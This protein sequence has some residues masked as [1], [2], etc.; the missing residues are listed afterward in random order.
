MFFKRATIKDMK[1]TQSILPCCMHSHSVLMGAH[2]SASTYLCLFVVH[3][4]VLV[5]LRHSVADVW[6]DGDLP[7]G[8]REI[9][10]SSEVY[11]WHIPT[12]T[13][14]Y[15]RPVAATNQHSPPSAD[16]DGEHD[17]CPEVKDCLKPPNE[18]RKAISSKVLL[19][20]HAKNASKKSNNVRKMLL[21]SFVAHLRIS[22]WCIC[23]SAF[24]QETLKSEYLNHVF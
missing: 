16:P 23:S 21:F 20:L 1:F 4:C 18:V 14:Q 12:G 5:Y 24:F 22:V 10:D 2:P 6:N 13:T 9:S 3:S 19:C 15:H 7:P 11:F 8:W 17:P